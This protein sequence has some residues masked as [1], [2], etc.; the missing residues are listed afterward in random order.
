VPTPTTTRARSRDTI[1]GRRPEVQST[2]HGRYAR[3][4]VARRMGRTRAAHGA[5]V[6]V[7]PRVPSR[8]SCRDSASPE[9]SDRRGKEIP[10]SHRNF[11]GVPRTP[12]PHDSRIVPAPC[13]RRSPSPGPS[14]SHSRRS[15]HRGAAVRESLGLLHP[16]P[17]T[18]RRLPRAGPPVASSAPIVVG[19]AMR[20]FTPFGRL[21]GIARPSGRS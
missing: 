15:P 4:K 18:P 19:S 20:R 16:L 14:F 17:S 6:A 8:R 12:P 13:G 2:S 11:R 1:D 5:E 3:S 7:G 21:A 9:L 10:R